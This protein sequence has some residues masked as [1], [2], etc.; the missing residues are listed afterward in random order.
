MAIF[1]ASV[2]VA[3]CSMGVLHLLQTRGGI[4]FS[5]ISATSGH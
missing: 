2:S 5:I 4:L 3:S 1:L